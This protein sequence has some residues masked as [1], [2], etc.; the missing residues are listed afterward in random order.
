MRA[1]DEREGGEGACAGYYFPQLILN[2]ELLL[3]FG[4]VRVIAHPHPGLLPLEKGRR[5]HASL[6]AVVR[7][8]NYFM[9]SKSAWFQSVL[10]R[11]RL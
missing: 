8:V 3:K 2:C 7:R 11:V 1:R 9:F 6:Y 10:I 5:L 4:G